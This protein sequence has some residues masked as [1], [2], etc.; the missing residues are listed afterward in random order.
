MSVNE[1]RALNIVEESMCFKEGHYEMPIPWKD[2]NEVIPNNQFVAEQRLTHLK[3]KLSRNS[4]LKDSYSLFMDDL[5]VEG[6]AKKVSEDDKKQIVWYL[7]Q[8]HVVNQKK[9][10][11]VRI[12]FDCAAKYQGKSLNDRVHQGSDLTN[13]LI[14]VLCRF[15]QE[16]VAIVAYI[17]A[18]YHQVRVD[19]KD[20][21]ALRFLWYSDGDITNTP[22]EYKML[23]H[24]FGG[25]WSLFCAN[26]A[27]QRTAIDNAKYFL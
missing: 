13:S 17:Q 14:G 4:S 5:V 26:Y 23:V 2:S 25:V 24:L 9:P 15:R 7:P 22:D 8:H 10:D 11:K 1:K 16:K 21:G 12:V 20:I 6:Y 18:M 19:P 3:K 27:L